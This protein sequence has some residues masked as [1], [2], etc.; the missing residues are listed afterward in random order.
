MLKA[1]VHIK[2]FI[3][4]KLITY[5]HAACELSNHL[6]TADGT[7]CLYALHT[8]ALLQSILVLCATSRL[9]D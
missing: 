6:T 4:L 3:V 9:L 2:L 1:N 5:H 7:C 8:A